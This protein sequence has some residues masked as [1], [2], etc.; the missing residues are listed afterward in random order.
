MAVAFENENIVEIYDLKSSEIRETLK[1]D[2]KVKRLFCNTHKEAINEFY[3]DQTNIVCLI[4]LFEDN[5]MD[6]YP[7]KYDKDEPKQLEVKKLRSRPSAGVELISLKFHR[8]NYKD[9][10]FEFFVCTYD[11]GT[12]CYKPSDEEHLVFVRPE[13][14]DIDSP[15]LVFTHALDKCHL[16]VERK[17]GCLLFLNW[18]R[19]K[20]SQNVEDDLEKMNSVAIG[21]IPGNFDDAR[22]IRENKIAAISLGMV[23]FYMVSNIK[24]KID[25]NAA[26]ATLEAYQ[27]YESI[28]ESIFDTKDAYIDLFRV[29]QIDAHFEP[30]T[31]L[32]N[33][34]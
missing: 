22:F 17:T 5:S 15:H 6:F 26:A 27:E 29:A 3:L 21:R 9:F 4:V 33:K 7:V 32:F 8:K 34:G 16:F 14:K 25:T 1:F 11:N 19:L 13:L 18:N 23:T 24:P 20:R 12:I 31:F 28:Y 30:I 2:M 10:K